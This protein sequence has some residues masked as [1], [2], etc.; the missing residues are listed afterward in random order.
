MSIRENPA[1]CSQTFLS[2]VVFLLQLWG[3]LTTKHVQT[4]HIIHRVSSNSCS[5]VHCTLQSFCTHIMCQD[6]GLVFYWSTCTSY[7]YTL[8][9]SLALFLSYYLMS[10]ALFLSLYLSLAPSLNYCLYLVLSQTYY[11]FVSLWVGF[12]MSS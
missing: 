8:S 9:V 7:I 3:Q 11:L 2:R 6:S 12:A 4:C 1:E 10:L 5:I